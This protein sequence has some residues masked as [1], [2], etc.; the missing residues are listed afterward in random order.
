MKKIVF[1]F[2][3][4][5]LICLLLGSLAH[6]ISPS[7]IWL[8]GIFAIGLPIT[9]ITIL[10]FGF[11]W[12]ISKKWKYLL[13]NIVI[14]LCCW[15]A[16][17]VNFGFNLS[18]NKE[19][20][21]FSIMSYNVRL[22]DLYNWTKNKNSKQNIL[23]FIQEE[24]AD[25]LCLQEFF[26]GKDTLKNQNI[27]DILSSTKYKYY[28]LNINAQNTRGVFSDVIFSKYPFIKE[29]SINYDSS[30]E[31]GFQFVDIKL[32]NKKIRIFNVHL[33]SIHLSTEELDYLDLGKNE[34]IKI[35][36]LP[37]SKTILYKLKNGFIQREAQVAKILTFKDNSFDA[38]I[39]CGDFNDLPC[40][41]A[42][43]TLKGNYND[44]FLEKGFGLGATYQNIAPFLRLDYILHSEDLH[45]SSFKLYK[46]SYS[47]HYPIKA[48]FKIK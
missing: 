39:I 10:C 46:Q 21:N 29:E 43:F 34:N 42:Y 6:L 18:N 32:N 28:A 8:L 12:L 36:R 11:I 22:L 27:K 1:L 38:G 9:F 47:D 44:A 30:S 19:D 24:D 33:Q 35:P 13:L 16:V 31:K 41:Y 5:T 4:L 15:K 40:S 20:I 17:T 2:N 7:K 3:L 45:C 48:Y 26:S 37:E 23:K 25:V 14:M